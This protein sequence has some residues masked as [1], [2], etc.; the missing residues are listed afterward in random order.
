MNWASNIYSR[1]ARRS[2]LYVDHADMRARWMCSN[3]PGMAGISASA[4]LRI[5]FSAGRARGG[6]ASYGSNGRYRVPNQ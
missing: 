1:R 3:S 2:G 5:G 6:G 4:R